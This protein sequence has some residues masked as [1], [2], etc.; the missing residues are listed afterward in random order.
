MIIADQCKPGEWRGHYTPVHPWPEDC[1]VQWGDLDGTRHPTFFEA[2]P[3]GTYLRGEG[4]TLEAAEGRAWAQHQREIA[5]PG[6]EW[7][8]VG[9]GQPERLDGVGWCVLCRRFESNVLPVRT[10]C[11]TCGLTVKLYSA[12]RCKPCLEATPDDLLTATERHCRWALRLLDDEAA[13]R[14]GVE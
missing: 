11:A 2:F 5:C 9:G 4:A 7:S 12:T 13:G 1:T 14:D 6:H 8:P 3:K 10:V